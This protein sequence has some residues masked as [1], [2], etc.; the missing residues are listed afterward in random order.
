MP[1]GPCPVGTGAREMTGAAV[2][3]EECLEEIPW[4]ALDEIP[5]LNPRPGSWMMPPR[6]FAAGTPGLYR[7]YRSAGANL[8]APFRTGGIFVAQNATYAAAYHRGLLDDEAR[9]WRVMLDI[10][11]P[12]VTRRKVTNVSPALRAALPP[13]TD[14]IILQTGDGNLGNGP[15]IIALDPAVLVSAT[16]TWLPGDIKIAINEGRLAEIPEDILADYPAAQERL[17]MLRANI[18]PDFPGRLF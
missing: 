15:V 14:A 9:L 18:G 17:D 2:H 5:A 11:K 6:E 1:A 8:R 4:W 13:G 3:A 7:G 10:R 16:E 12:F